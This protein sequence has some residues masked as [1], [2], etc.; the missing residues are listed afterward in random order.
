MKACGKKWVEA[1]T[2]TL[3]ERE[4]LASIFALIYNHMLRAEVR[5]LI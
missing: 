5:F 1:L 4:M 2:L 3:S